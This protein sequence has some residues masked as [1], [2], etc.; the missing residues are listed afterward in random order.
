MVRVRIVNEVG[1]L[2][3]VDALDQLAVQERILDVDLVHMP[4]PRIS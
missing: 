4:T 1:R 3:T 2:K